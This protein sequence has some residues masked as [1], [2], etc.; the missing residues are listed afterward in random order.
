VTDH[1]LAERGLAQA[2]KTR[3]VQPYAGLALRSLL[4][5]VAYYFGS[6]LG[7]TLIFPSSYISVIW[8]PNTILLVALL[9][10]PPRQW[11]WLLLIAFPVHILAQAQYGVS[12]PAAGLYYIYDCA[13]VVTAATALRRFGLRELTLTD[14]RQTLIFIAVTTIAVASASLV[15]SP[16]IV[17]FWLGGDLWTPWYLAFLSN[18]LPFLIVSPGLVIALTRGTAIMRRASLPQYMEFTFLALSLLGCGIG[19]FGLRPQGVEKLPALLYAPLPFLLW[20]AV[21]FGPGGLSFSFLGFALMVSFNAVAGH[22]PFVTESGDN[23]LWLQIFLLALYL[24]LLLLASLVEE[25]SGKEDVLEES[26][27]RYPA[28]VMASAETVWRANARGEGFLITPHWQNLTGQSQDEM[29][30]SGWLQAVHA[31]DRE[32]SARLWQQAMDEK[33]AYENELRVRSRDGSYRHFHVQAVPILAAD[34]TVHEWV[35]ANVDIT[36]RKLAEEQ[37]RE[38]QNRF[39]IATA[40]GG[41]SVWDLDLATNTVRVDPLTPSLLRSQGSQTATYEQWLQRIHP[42]DLE[43]VLGAQ[44]RLLEAATSGHEE[45][46]SIRPE[47]GFRVLDRDGAMRWVLARGTV[48]KQDNG[49]AYRIV[50]TA[51]DITRRKQTEDALRE[52]EAKSRAI[53]GALPD[54]MFIQTIEGVYL[55]Y[56]AKDPRALLV[57]PE[58]FLGK[59]MKEVLPAELAR[60]FERSF[61]LAAQSDG[62]VIHEYT[63]PIQGETRH[64]EARIMPYNGN[65]LLT[66]VRDITERKRAEQALRHSEARLKTIMDNCPA[67]MFLKD[68]QGRYLYANPAFEHITQ[69]TSEEIV[70]KTDFEIFPYEQAAAF[71]ANDVKALESGVP[72]IFEEIACHA[73]GPHTSV[74]CKF[75]LLDEE[76]RIY[77]TGGM[78]T[79]ITERKRAEEALR[80]A[81]A[82]VERLT[83]RLQAENIYLRTELSGAHRYEKIIGQSKA[84]HRVI[85]QIKQVAATD[86]TVLVLGETGVGKELIA[87]AVHESSVRRR[88]PLVKVNCA[89]LP[90]PLIESEL[91]GHEKGAFT[92]A[93]VRQL[94]R[95]E[96]AHGGTIFLDEIGDLPLSLQ[97]KLLRVLQEGEFERLGSGKTIK[98]NARVIA[99]TSRNLLEAMEHGTFR[100]DLYYRL[101]V[102]P[103]NVP[104]LRERKE[105]IELL[106]NAFL[107]E[108]GWR[109]D[110]RFDALPRNVLSE[111]QRYD[112]PGNIREL[113]NIIERAAVISAGKHLELPEEWKLRIA[114]KEQAAV[115]IPSLEDLVPEAQKIS[116][117]T[118]LDELEK[119]HITRVLEQ[120][121]W[122]IE[123]PKGAALILGLHPSTLR[124]RMQK[125]GLLKSRATH[126]ML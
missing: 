39:A 12:P 103:I 117:A 83:E 71:H 78:V 80:Q 65:K 105:D 40:A 48:L 68:T 24:P 76:G 55:D 35:G 41:V 50:G 66:L 85:Q 15:W 119:E 84:I 61:A 87:R 23:V 47:I 57:P 77:A 34:G 1:V 51:T 32:R 17:S 43:L 11:P 58:K 45:N 29:R 120:T 108:V 4:V 54:L 31:D 102:Y 59:N 7:Y 8:P 18:L 110:K 6:L 62:P 100:S 64:Y 9:L 113:Q 52:S 19:V 90:A 92:G 112:W 126:N 38:S 2:L 33:R 121:K 67:M 14:L 63:V 49:R 42:D 86:V 72:T 99:A 53:L 69:R 28:L 125:L 81:L 30:E 74:V 73:D 96:L 16:L 25:Q 44:R 36:E 79:D 109:L 123:G 122:R 56:H 82:E 98:V 101:N 118:K 115:S 26:E 70:G 114:P 60:A 13:V 37:L 124:S 104:P 22:G 21:R 97:A 107:R 46:S 106:A 3:P 10:S 88:R 91:F 116:Q 75:P 93:T 27:T 89:T 20:A 111:L 94:G 95:F 5:C